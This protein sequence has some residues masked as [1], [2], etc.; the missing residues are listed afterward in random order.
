MY[1]VTNHIAESEPLRATAREAAA[2]LIADILALRDE[3][4]SG[5]SAK[6]IGVFARIRHLISLCRLLGASGHVSLQN[7]EVLIESLDELGNFI[8]ASQRSI[9]SESVTISREEL[10]DIGTVTNR[11]VKDKST[12]IVK[13][14]TTVKDM[15]RLSD[16][17]GDRKRTADVRVRNILEVVRHGGELGIREIAANLPEYSEK[18]IQRELLS[19]V[20]KGQLRKTGL[21]RWSKYALPA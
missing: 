3:M 21:K 14:S 10:L 2:A 8:S 1:L 5:R 7:A 6:L 12:E 13:D 9:L 17:N 4:R 19:L 20:S 16:K 18:M 15:R 11:S